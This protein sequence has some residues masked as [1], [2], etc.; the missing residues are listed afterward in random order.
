MIKFDNGGI[1]IENP[2]ELPDL[3]D[4]SSVFLDFETSSG[5]EKLDSLN[6]WHSCK[7]AGIA[8]TVDNC[9]NAFYI[10]YQHWDKSQQGIACFWLQEIIDNCDFW[11]NHNVKYDA[12][13]AAN[14]LQ[15]D[16]PRHV[17]LICTIVLAK[18]IDSDRIMRGGYGLDALSLGWLGEDISKYEQRLKPYLVK[19]QDYG[20]VPPDILGE[21]GCQDAL[22]NRRLW[23]FILSQIPEESAG[24]WNTE[25]E[26]TRRLW[27][28]ER[29][30]MH[31]KTQELQVTQYSALNRMLA[32]DEE[33]TRIAGRSFRPH[34]NEDVYD[35]LCNQYGLPVLAYTKDQ[36][37][38]EETTNPSFDKHALKMYMV[39]PHAPLELL[40]LMQEY[41][42]LAQ[43][44]S[45]F[46]KPWQHLQVSSYLHANYNQCVRTGRMSCSDPNAQQLSELAKGLVHPKPGYAF[47]SMDASQIEFRFIV[48]YIQDQHAIQAYNENPD[49][50]FHEWVANQCGIK[51]KPAKTVNFAIAFGEGKKKLTKQLASDADIVGVIKDQIEEMIATDK[52]KREQEQLYFANLAGA[53]ALQ[54]YNTYHRTFPT[55]KPTMKDVERVLRARGHVRNMYGRRRHLPVDKAYRGFN[56][57]NQSSAA[58]WMKERTV[59]L[60]NMIDGT[61]IEFVASVHDEILLQAPIE[62]ANDPRTARDLIA[63]ME[64]LVIP[65]RVPVRCNIG[66]SAKDWK[67]ASKSVKD[68]G[69]SGPLY[70]NKSE[71]TYLD[72]IARVAV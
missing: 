48:H 38:G 47:I 36:S 31:V 69:V 3:V 46:L 49:V 67:T 65:L 8:I 60:C 37:T 45:L 41:R 27:E 4:A 21:Y 28:M 40:Q 51:R 53:R 10:P 19:N 29:N 5:D 50:D 70:Y 54:V 13:V 22:T 72:H 1:L 57:L 20:R 56:T 7:V 43:F 2:S 26:L 66:I 39:Q 58:D 52:I 11:I 14:D 9:P 42:K 62:I 44:E 24:V 18:L 71:A 30:G 15:I 35:V 68:G 61:P 17:K 32:I 6:P 34:V 23:G 16:I 25:I 64:T 12:H 33:L 63:F 55:L 59:G